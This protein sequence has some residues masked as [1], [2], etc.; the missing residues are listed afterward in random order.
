LVAGIGCIGFGI[1]ATLGN[2]EVE[3]CFQP[4]PILGCPVLAQFYGR[5]FFVGLIL[6]IASAIGFLFTLWS[7]RRT[8]VPQGEAINCP[9]RDEAEPFLWESLLITERYQ[10]QDRGS[11][12][13]TAFAIGI[14]SEVL[15]V[16]GILSVHHSVT[17]GFEPCV[18]GSHS[19][20]CFSSTGPG[21]FLVGLASL[22]ASAVGFLFT[23]WSYRRTPIPQGETSN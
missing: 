20:S 18:F 5:V 19:G 11:E 10:K 6:L 9:P 7:C 22:V 23:L 8:L 15:L 14:V 3:L 16:A 1:F 13:K 4:N 12:L 17:V 21:Y 2:F